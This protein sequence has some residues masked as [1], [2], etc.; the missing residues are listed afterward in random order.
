MNIIMGVS[1]PK[2]VYIF[3]NLYY[4]LVANKHNVLVLA[5]DKEITI[6]LLDKFKIPYTL[7]GKNQKRYYLKI[8]QVIK[9][10]FTTLFY[11]FKFKPD[12]F[13]GFGYFHFAFVSFLLRK[14]FLFP[15]DT[16]VAK[17]VH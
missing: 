11:S 4:K 6:D 14:P 1:H 8:L 7:L 17:N 2:H 10:F 13:L 5:S 15:E 3:K 9:F 16:E 12:I